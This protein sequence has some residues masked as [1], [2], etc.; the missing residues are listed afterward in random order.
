MIDWYL[1]TKGTL[2]KLRLSLYSALEGDERRKY[3]S[4]SEMNEIFNNLKVL[5]SS[6]YPGENFA[7]IAP[8]T[9]FK[10]EKGW[11]DLLFVHLPELEENLDNHLK[12]DVFVVSEQ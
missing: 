8:K 3:P 12:D 5:W 11:F 1:E 6:R 7:N 10:N 4:S 9:N 2:N